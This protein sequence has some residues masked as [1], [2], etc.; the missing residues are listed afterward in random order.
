MKVIPYDTTLLEAFRFT[1]NPDEPGWPCTMLKNATFKE[2]PGGWMVVIGPGA[3]N[4]GD[5]V[6]I[7]EDD[8][9]TL[10]TDDVFQTNYHEVLHP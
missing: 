1:G 5:W 6:V 2:R 9:V 4:R 3:M 10:M 8:T 7:H